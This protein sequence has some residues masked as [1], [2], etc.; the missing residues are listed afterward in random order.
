MTQALTPS[1][2]QDLLNGPAATAPP[3]LTN[4]LVDPPTLNGA[5]I[6]T[7]VVCLLI[8]TVLVIMRTY[9]RFFVIRKRDSSDGKSGNSG[10]SSFDLTGYPVFCLLCYCAY[11]A[12]TGLLVKFSQVGGG[13]HI[14]DVTVQNTIDGTYVS[15]GESHQ[16]TAKN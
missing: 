4:N 12:L 2:I 3:G 15:S 5:F 16:K 14:W 10:V 7:V 8:S 13:R 9:T 11:I 1:Q 6:G